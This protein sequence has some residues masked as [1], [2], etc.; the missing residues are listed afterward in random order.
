MSMD[1]RYVARSYG[2][3]CDYVHG[4]TGRYLLLQYLH[5][6]HPWWSYIARRKERRYN[7]TRIK[8]N[9]AGFCLI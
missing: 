4:W 7:D 6:H 9:N 2:W 1:G 8:F 3:R 5:F